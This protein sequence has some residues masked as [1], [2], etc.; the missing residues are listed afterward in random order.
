MPRRCV[1][2]GVVSEADERFICG[3]CISDLPWNRHACST[4]ALPL[5]AAVAADVGCVQCQMKL[6]PMA[7]TVAPLEYAFPVDAAIKALKFSRKLFFVPAFGD[8]LHT[9]FERLPADIDALLPVPLNRWRQLN[10]GFN[11]ANE[12]AR[13]LSKLTGLRIL[14]QVSRPVATPYQSGLDAKARSENLKAAF[15]VDKRIT[16]RHVLIVDDVITTGETCRQLARTV[17][18]GGAD[19]VSAIAIA[20]A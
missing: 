10:R 8:V 5:P 13:Q 7:A 3:G 19:Q 18:A 12:L 15:R 4:C 1:F 20:R 9:G 17:L 14:Q 2:C 6:P 16:A 11:Q